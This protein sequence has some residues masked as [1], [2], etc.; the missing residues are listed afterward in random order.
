MVYAKNIYYFN[1]KNSLP[2]YQINIIRE[3]VLK[4]TYKIVTLNKI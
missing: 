2:Y 3:N 1:F 4:S